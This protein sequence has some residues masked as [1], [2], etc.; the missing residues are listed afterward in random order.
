MSEKRRKA[1]VKA[2]R[3]LRYHY[4]KAVARG[5]F[6]RQKQL[7]KKSQIFGIYVK[8]ANF[9]GD[10]RILE[11]H[12]NDKAQNIASQKSHMALYDPKEEMLT[13]RP[14]L[15]SSIVP[16]EDSDCLWQEKGW[17]STLD[18]TSVVAPE[19]LGGEITVPS[20]VMPVETF[21]DHVIRFVNSS[22][23]VIEAVTSIGGSIG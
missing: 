3:R 2:A 22:N 21:F 4:S 15:G 6:I 1:S 23:D 7:I 14:H 12:Y 5:D 17:A 10:A 9:Q 18:K 11:L 13:D 16:G 20:P 19:W 8:R